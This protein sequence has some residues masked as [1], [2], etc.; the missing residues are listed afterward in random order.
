MIGIQRAD[1][2]FA[3]HPTLAALYDKNNRIEPALAMA[4]VACSSDRLG[5]IPI[6]VAT[7][8]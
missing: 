5:P 3:R 7:E 6:A 8:R 2:A 1:H 4:L